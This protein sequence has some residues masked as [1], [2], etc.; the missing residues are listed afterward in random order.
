M[1]GNRDLLLPDLV[2][3]NAAGAAQIAQAIWPY[4]RVPGRAPGP[5]LAGT[6]SPRSRPTYV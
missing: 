6:T 4:V 5:R 1:I 3:P 2:H